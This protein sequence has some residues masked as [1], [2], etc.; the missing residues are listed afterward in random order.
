M[1]G[2]VSKVTDAIG[3][4]DVKGTEKRAEQA[5]AA[6]R[7][8]ARIGG[9]AA[10]FRPVGMTTRF[11][12]STFTETIDPDTGLPRVTAAGYKLSPELLALQDALFGMTGGALDYAQ[13]AQ[14]AAAPLGGAAQSLFGL[15]QQ[16]LAES[17]EAARQ[18]Y[19]DQQQA[20]LATPRQREEERLASSVFGRGRAGLNIGDI[21]QPELAALA[22]AR[23]QQ[24]LAL[25]AQ[26]EQ[27]AQQQIG[28]GSG[29][30]GQ[31]AGMLGQ[32]YAIPTQALGPL[33]TYLGTIGSI[34]D[35]GQDPFR[36]GLQVG[37]MVQ[38]GGATGGNLLSSGLSSA[39]LTQQRGGDAASA[40]LTGFMNN[41][42]N[43][44]IGA[45]SGG[46]SGFGGGSAGSGIGQYASRAGVNFTGQGVYG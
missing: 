31:G 45:A 11:G 34:E 4:T 25:A 18:R 43:S 19:F 10:A 30:F 16:Y 39:A 2:V 44:A 38:Q 36:L 37:G 8:A 27:A 14:D 13:G 5:A 24:D 35:L 46:F 32:Q 29:L 1:G 42:F 40:Q 28:F 15:G 17:P 12:T 41:L 22:S 9:I 20:L 26:A 3:L 23:R 33:Q 6:Q 21:G 7:E